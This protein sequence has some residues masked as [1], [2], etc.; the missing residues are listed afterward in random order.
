MN[1]KNNFKFEILSILIILVCAIILV[2]PQIRSNA[3]I[4]GTDTVFH[5]NSFYETASQILNGKFSYFQSN[6]GYNGSARIVSALYGPAINYL[7]GIILALSKSWVT[8]QVVLNII[9]LWVAGSN[10]YA[11]NRYLNVKRLIAIVISVLYMFSPVVLYWV[12]GHNFTGWGAAF[13]PLLCISAVRVIQD[14]SQPVNVVLLSITMSILIQVHLVTSLIGIL[15]LVLFYSFGLYKSRDKKK[16]LIKVVIAA[17]I[18]L[19]LTANV[20]GAI[21]DVYSGNTVVS[22][23]PNPDLSNSVMHFTTT[24][25]NWNHYGLIFSFI[26]IAQTIYT[27]I[28]FRYMAL[29]EKLINGCGI[30]FLI[31]SSSLMP[32]KRVGNHF[33]ILK[34]MLQFPERLSVISFV[35]LLL[36]IGIALSK[37]SYTRLVSCSMLVIAS[38]I[39]I[40]ARHLVQAPIAH[41]QGSDINALYNGERSTNDIKLLKKSFQNKNKLNAGLLL[42]PKRTPDYLPATPSIKSAEYSQVDPYNLYKQQ[43]LDNQI[44]VERKVNKNKQIVKWINTDQEKKN[45]QLPI[46]KYNHSQVVVNG[47][48]I[49]DIKITRIGAMIIPSKVGI[50]TLEISYH[51]N[52]II[53]ILML[54]TIIAWLLMAVVVILYWN[55]LF[56]RLKSI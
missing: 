16:L 30:I 25:Y 50:N 32:W 52:G 40:N 33:P 2:I 22:T 20:W 45:I 5:I 6:F 11:L 54:N 34:T 24:S 53:H 43:V 17:G 1:R 56:K 9:V 23:F 14:E 49:K 7:G 8:L 47:K 29:V 10:M 3:V 48:L 15:I 31:G 37:V 35:L 28:K 18:T 21:L 27:L 38:I 39:F 12:I 4:F 13:L 46:I 41:W 51:P 36:G 26:F 19:L 44:I 55:N 42:L